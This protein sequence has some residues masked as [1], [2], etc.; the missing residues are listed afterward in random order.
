MNLLEM[1]ATGLDRQLVL[2]ARGTIYVQHSSRHLPLKLSNA[3]FRRRLLSS[4]GVVS[5]PRLTIHF[6]SVS[7]TNSD[8]SHIGSELRSLGRLR[9]RFREC[10]LRLNSIDKPCPTRPTSFSP[11][12]PFVVCLFSSLAQKTTFTL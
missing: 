10:H 7:A 12:L 11:H 6:R 9:G 4:I 8:P 3:P 2:I 5:V 1:L